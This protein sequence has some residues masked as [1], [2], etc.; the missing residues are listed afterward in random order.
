MRG[1][2]EQGSVKLSRRR[3]AGRRGRR[4]I[5]QPR[6]AVGFVGFVALAA[7]EGGDF[8]LCFARH[9]G[10]LVGAALGREGV[11]GAKARLNFLPEG[12]KLIGGFG[13][14]AEPGNSA[15]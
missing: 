10:E 8:G 1:V 5:A 7:E 15:S 6:A 4:E 9:A 11:D 2:V 12:K 13:C 3:T 14:E